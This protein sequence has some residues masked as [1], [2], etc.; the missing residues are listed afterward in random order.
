MR[1]MHLLTKKI[2]GKSIPFEE[3]WNSPK[4]TDPK[5]LKT[6]IFSPVK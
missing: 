6:S 4:D 1:M 2:K 3:Y 5:D